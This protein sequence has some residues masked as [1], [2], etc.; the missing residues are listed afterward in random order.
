MK[1]FTKYIT[2]IGL[3]I[4]IVSCSSF[5]V[6][7]D[8]IRSVGETDAGTVLKAYVGDII[9]TKY[10]YNSRDF[11]RVTTTIS[12]GLLAGEIALTDSVM[13]RSTVNGQSGACG[14]AQVG[15]YYMQVCLIDADRDNVFEAWE[16]PTGNSGKLKNNP[17]PYS[18]QT[19]D[20]VDGVK[21]ELIYQG[22]D[23]ET[24]RF[25]YREYIKDIVRP[26]YDQTVEYNL[27]EDKIVTFR[28]MRMLIESAT[29]QDITYRIISGTVELWKSTLK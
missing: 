10:D 25:R 18:Y 9:Y 2:G 29:N 1:N 28:G 23:D 21:K 13:L 19:A 14:T 20:N 11:T 17:V 22:I 24:L 27:E 7:P 8:Y 16:M 15:L 26:A 4:I 6:K 3:T 5:T 12:L